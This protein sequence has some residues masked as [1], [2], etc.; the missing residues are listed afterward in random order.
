MEAQREAKARKRITEASINRLREVIG[1]LSPP[2][3][4]VTNAWLAMVESA[5]SG[6][7]RKTWAVIADELGISVPAAKSRWGRACEQLRK[8]LPAWRDLFPL[9][10]FCV[11]HDPYAVALEQNYE[12]RLNNPNTFASDLIESRDEWIEAHGGDAPASGDL[13]NKLGVRGGE[14]SFA[15]SRQRH[16]ESEFSGERASFSGES[17]S[18]DDEGAYQ[19][20]SLKEGRGKARPG[21]PRHINKDLRPGSLDHAEAVC[22]TMGQRMYKL[23]SKQ[24]ALAGHHR[25]AAELAKAQMMP[26]PNIT[27]EQFREAV[28]AMDQRQ[29]KL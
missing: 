20:L 14:L 27:P 5:R 18:A 3:Q 10:P 17:D 19:G 28:R 8:K 24:Q 1:T 12:K 29:G 25:R 26:D 11:E 2:L 21:V 22:R 23:S 7:S 16:G 15:V 4:D 9:D 6:N 13:S